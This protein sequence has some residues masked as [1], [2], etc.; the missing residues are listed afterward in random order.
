MAMD[1]KASPRPPRPELADLE[2]A[3]GYAF[4]D[5]ERLVRALTHSSARG[6]LP[7]HRMD[8]VLHNERLEFLGDRVLGL[9]MAEAVF[10]GYPHAPEGELARH[11]NRLVC[12]E[13]CARVADR[14][15]LGQHLIM[16][17]GERASQRA[18]ATILAD[19]CEALLGA[20]YRDGGFEAAR[21]VIVRLWAAELANDAQPQRAIQKDAKTALQEW[22]Q[23]RAMPLPRYSEIGRSGPD[24]APQFLFAVQLPGHTRAE[25]AGDSKRAAEHAAAR[26]FLVREGIWPDDQAADIPQ[27]GGD[28]T[29]GA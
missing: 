16:G 28:R 10:V 15:G 25:G 2:S 27:V 6:L 8:A 1:H 22:A 18:H 20:V 7:P 23:A 21:G 29:D 12:K 3:I 17:A 14:L 9:A 26:A 19:A 4:A 5:R 13:A 11:F 24:H